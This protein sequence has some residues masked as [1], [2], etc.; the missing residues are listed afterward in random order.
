MA[1]YLK[2]TK[3]EGLY[4][5]GKYFFRTVNLETVDLD[6]LAKHMAAHNTPYST[7]CIRGVLKDMCDCIKEI[8]LEGKKVKIGDLAIISIGVKSSGHDSASD[9]NVS[10]DIRGL[11][12][13]AQGTG[14]L[15]LRENNLMNDVSFKVLDG[16]ATES[17]PSD[18]SSSSDG[19][20]GSS[21]SGGSSDGTDSSDGNDDG[22]IE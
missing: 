12:F 13:N 2:K 21:S 8:L 22:A 9:L 6:A 15:S 20:S 14:E 10:T 19:S 7:G 1:I 11:R 4:S 5:K 17:T 18:G 16:V 3:V